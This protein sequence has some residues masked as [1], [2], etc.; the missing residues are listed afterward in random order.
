MPREAK[1]PL[2]IPKR[3]R[4]P[5]GYSVRVV[6]RTLKQL[7][8]EVGSEVYGWWDDEERVIYLGKDLP[9]AKKRHVLIHEAKHMWADYELYCTEIGIATP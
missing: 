9:T 7:Q 2:R 6:Q 4:L 3:I 8:E 1:G 5:F